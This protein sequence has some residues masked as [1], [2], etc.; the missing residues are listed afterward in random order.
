MSNESNRP[1]KLLQPLP[2]DLLR[3]VRLIEHAAASL[4]IPFLL[5][6]AAARD[7]LLVNLWGMRAGRATADIDFAFSVRDWA[8]FHALRDAL[9]TSRA[10]QRVSHQEQRLAYTDPEYGFTVP[11]DLVPFHG[12][13]RADQTIEWPPEGDFVMNVAGFEEALA[14][15]LLI[16]AEPGLVVRVT[17]I[18][19]L[20]LLKLVAWLDRNLINNKDAT[21]IFALLESYA[22]AGNQDRLYDYEYEVLEAMGHDLTI[23]GAY[24]VGRDAAQLAGSEAEA[25]VRKILTSERHMDRLLNQVLSSGAFPERVDVVDGILQNFRSGF[26]GNK[27]V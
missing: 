23:A 8:H 14:S 20:L 13:A 17:S 24:L 9:V 6:G 10:F 27:N 18:P 11:V 5:A 22:L 15:A 26:L 12:V 3:V 4:D 25:Q 1:L 16:E 7:T 21:D 2:E 19:G